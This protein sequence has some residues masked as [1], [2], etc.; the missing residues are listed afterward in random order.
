MQLK[1]YQNDALR[2]LQRFFQEAQVLGPK[3]AFETITQE[4]ELADRLGSFGGSY[5]DALTDRPDIPYVCLRLP[6]GGGKTVLAAHAVKVARDV[7]IQEDYPLVLWL[8]PTNTIRQQTA[9][10]LNDIHHPYRQVLEEAFSGRVRIFDISEFTQIQPQILQ[11]N[12]CVVVGTIQ[13]LRVSNT[14]GR[15]VYAHNENM[16]THFSPLP[17]QTSGLEKLD[18]GSI[19][20]SFANLVNVHRPLMILDEAHKANT[21]LTREM[22]QRL[23]PCAI[24]EFTATPR[25]KSNILYNATAQELKQENMIK[26]PIMLSE[27]D[28]WQNAVSGAILKRAELAE[29]ARDDEDYLRPIILFQA[30]NRNQE[31]N[32]QALRNHLIGT[33]RIPENKIAVATGNLRE[34]Q[35]V[36][37][38]DPQ[39]PIEYVITVEALREGWD[40]SFAYVFCSVSRIQNARNVEQ[41]FGRVLRMPYAN[42]R[43]ANRLNRAYAYVSEP[44]FGDAARA[45][46]DKLVAMG[47]EEHEAQDNIQPEIPGAGWFD[48]N[49]DTPSLFD[50]ERPKFRHTV[51]ASQEDLAALLKISHERLTVRKIDDAQAEITVTGSIDSSLEKSIGTAVSGVESTRLAKA[52]DA[53]RTEKAHLFSPAELGEKF[54][55]P[56]LMVKIQ[57]DL[58]IADTDIFME[59]REWSILSH[60]RPTGRE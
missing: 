40:C 28:T 55:V 14:E 39:C 34:L 9:Q 1:Q 17:Q 29:I 54:S 27:H 8:V 58:E 10:T 36:N 5:T 33:E 46:S 48:I 41:L 24:V 42:R 13:T 56:R 12:C 19:K 30:Q 53:Y 35:D 6:T 18:N 25:P 60:P 20:F 15:R 2:T 21:S 47:F 37:L 11:D 44:T 51:S 3:Y 23:N 50:F 38:F 16:M 52:I 7:W 49:G 43:K 31:V 32:V 22:Q 26:L 4:P 59:Y 45:L 57:G